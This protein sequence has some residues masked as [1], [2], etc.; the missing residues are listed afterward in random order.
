MKGDVHL[1]FGSV[2]GMLQGSR[3]FERAMIDTTEDF[4]EHGIVLDQKTL[5]QAWEFGVAVYEVERVLLRSESPERVDT[6]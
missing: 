6:L 3:S 5:R 2:G 4:E 1:R